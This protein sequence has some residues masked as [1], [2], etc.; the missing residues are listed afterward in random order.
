MLVSFCVAHPGGRARPQ[1][2]A[3]AAASEARANCANAD[4]GPRCVN[5]TAYD[6]PTRARARARARPRFWQGAVCTGI[7]VVA[8]ECGH[9]AF[10]KWQAVNDGVGLV[11]HSALLVP[12]YSW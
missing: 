3:S 1:L 9:Q 7:W 4:D 2:S 6:I 12:Y 11:L 8:H 10:S 5:H